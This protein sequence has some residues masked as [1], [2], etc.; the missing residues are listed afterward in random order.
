M[1]VPMD[2]AKNRSLKE[3]RSVVEHQ[4]LDHGSFDLQSSGSARRI[5]R[6][7]TILD[8]GD[9]GYLWLVDDSGEKLCLAGSYG[10]PDRELS[11]SFRP[12]DSI[13][14][15]VW[16]TGRDI[17]IEDIL[18]D[19][20][21]NDGEVSSHGVRSII[22]VP[23]IG[24][25]KI[26][27]VIGVGRQRVRR[28]SQNDIH[29]LTTLAALLS[30]LQW[31]AGDA[32]LDQGPA[33]ALSSRP[34][35]VDLNEAIESMLPAI[36]R[37]ARLGLDQSRAAAVVVWVTTPYAK[38]M[39][40]MTG[41]GIAQLSQGAADAWA[42]HTVTTLSAAEGT[43][44]VREGPEMELME[45]GQERRTTALVTPVHQAEKTAG[46]AAFVF[47]AGH[48]SAME[49][50]AGTLMMLAEVAEAEA[51]SRE[52][53]YRADEA[54]RK[55]RQIQRHKDSFVI[56]AGHHLRTPLTSIKGFAQ[57]L[58]RPGGASA[59]NGNQPGTIVSES[60]R[61]AQVIDDIVSMERMEARIVGLLPGVTSLAP[62]LAGV[63]EAVDRRN[64]GG[65]L[66]LSV[67][68]AG[69]EIWADR[70]ETGTALAS[71]VSS[72]AA[73]GSEGAPLQLTAGQDG[74]YVRVMVKTGLDKGLRET[75]ERML[76]N[77]FSMDGEQ[78]RT[79]HAVA[80]EL[81]IAKNIIEAEGG[82]IISQWKRSGELHLTINLP[83]STHPRG[84]R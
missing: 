41:T 63:K 38:G 56:A 15:Y 47:F 48:G 9:Y 84:K 55:L 33:K 39:V 8:R 64:G 67:P 59:L 20:M 16:Q 25:G 11:T 43:P 32:G 4:L 34:T 69:L 68:P 82:L 27:G 46:L 50:N 30:D 57:L 13:Q 40:A 24:G 37:S 1:P 58:S 28:F 81:Y 74:D 2:A 26:R 45:S 65:R 52:L 44:V 18:T 42:H 76:T 36:S 60:D 49:K 12:G 72:L 23:L 53:A 70:R 61:L 22:A 80:R 19:S 17:S 62:L 35:R 29:S 54:G 71:I 79:S 78:N 75:W 77:P 5:A 10:I 7:A 3:V 66:Y 14:S 83:T 73:L 6:L 31:Q 21:I 51:S